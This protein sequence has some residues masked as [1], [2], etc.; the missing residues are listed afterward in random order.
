MFGSI[1]SPASAGCHRLIRDG[2]KPITCAQ[3]V[4]EELNL[5]LAVQHQTARE[6]LP[7][8]PLEAALLGH[9]SSEPLHIDAIG[10]AADVPAALVSSTLTMMELK[11]LVRHVGGMQYVRG[12]A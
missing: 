1:F 7:G 3:D 8:D 2:A 11:G 6:E 5:T 12:R 4:L 10:R 9:L